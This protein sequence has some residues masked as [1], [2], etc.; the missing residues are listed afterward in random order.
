MDRFNDL[1]KKIT[2]LFLTASEAGL[3]LISLI[4]VIYLLLGGDSGAF[5]LS[6]VNNLSSLIEALT[7]Q[8]IVSVAIMFV[9]YA[10]MRRKN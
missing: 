7:P 4:L 3:A 10:W 1:F 9:A 6:V 2:A 8:A 5:T